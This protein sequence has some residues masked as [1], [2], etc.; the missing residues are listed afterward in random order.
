MQVE[1]IGQSQEGVDE[2][3]KYDVESPKKTSSRRVSFQTVANVHD[4]V[5]PHKT[6]SKRKSGKHK[7]SEKQSRS[8][9]KISLPPSPSPDMKK[10]HP[11]KTCISSRY[12][13]QATA[14]WLM[15]R[16]VIAEYEGRRS[17]SGVQSPSTSSVR[18]EPTRSVGSKSSVD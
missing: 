8:M 10:A 3:D 12:K 16:T 17:R 18:A 2:G 13:K 7:V 1:E 6:P 11:T 15:V 14:D 5:T 9:D 4:E